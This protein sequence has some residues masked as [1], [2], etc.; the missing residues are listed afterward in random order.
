MKPTFTFDTRAFNA[1]LTAR[2]ARSRRTVVEVVNQSAFN[3][4]ARAMRETRASEGQKVRAYLGAP[5]SDNRSTGGGAAAAM[6][7]G[8]NSFGSRHKR[9]ARQLRRVLLIAQAAFYKKHGYGLGKGKSNKRTKRIRQVTAQRGSL[10]GANG[11]RKVTDHGY[12]QAAKRNKVV[13]G[14]D[15]GEA[16]KA[17]VG[18]IFNKNVRS[19]G[20][21]RA[22]WVPVLRAL[23]PLAKFR[24]LA[25][26]LK[27]AVLWKTSSAVGTAAPA[28]QGPDAVRAV[29]TVGAGAPRMSQGAE[30]EARRATQAAIDGETKDMVRHLAS[31]LAKG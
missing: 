14:S 8:G 16:M 21:L 7:A 31:E 5:M 30:I 2:V 25:K 19:A 24:G 13:M 11:K 10:F 27:Y 29:L 12:S 9:G 3:V 26:G 1:A 4:A 6:N 18:K 22:M 23:G 17:Y 15:Y 28:A 20:Y